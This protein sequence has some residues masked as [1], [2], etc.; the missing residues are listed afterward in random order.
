MSK[1]LVSSELI[2]KEVNLKLYSFICKSKDKVKRSALIN[3][4]EDGGLKMQDLE[5]MISAQIIMCVKKYVENHESPWM[6]VL[7][8]YL[9][10]EGGKIFIT[11]QF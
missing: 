1:A 5:S 7:D 2:I 4:N 11:I 6:Y 9:K 3:D 8:F 10:K